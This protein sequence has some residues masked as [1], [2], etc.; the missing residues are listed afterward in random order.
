MNYH[1]LSRL[2]S[3]FTRYIF[4]LLLGLVWL[5]AAQ[6]ATNCAT[7][8]DIP[9]LECEA[10]V[11]LYTNLDGANWETSPSNNW[12]QN[13]SPCSWWGVNCT[14]SP[15]NTNVKVIRLY[16]RHFSGSLPTEL[17]NLSS[18]EELVLQ[19]LWHDNN[20][21]TYTSAISGTIPTELGN[22]TNLRILDL[23]YNNL[24]GSIPS[25]LGNLANLEELSLRDNEFYNTSIPVELGNLTNL[26]ILD[27]YYCHLT[28]SIPT[29]LGNLSSLEVL[30]LGYNGL[31][32]PIP[33]ELG[34]LSNLEYLRLSGCYDYD[35]SYCGGGTT[36]SL[37]GSIPTEL[38]NL[39]NLKKLYL[40][41]NQL[42]GDIPSSFIA[43][44][45]PNLTYIR[46]ECNQLTAS[47][48][49]V[50]TFLNGLNSVWTNQGESCPSNTVPN[51]PTN[52]ATTTISQTA[53]DLTWTDNSNIETGFIV[54]RD[55]IAI[56]T[57]TTDIANYSDTDLT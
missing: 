50:V 41:D 33:A 31:S 37:S 25:Q 3:S 4:P 47:D 20:W 46:L 28:G 24:S 7:Q 11:A 45:L 55:G 13:D 6:A 12:N 35:N 39:T 44:N 16:E 48:T 1:S 17:G 21:D 51:I 32:G 34:N 15:P 9:Q 53:I 5:S 43:T 29:Q 56:A 54:K 19:R 18:L 52:L 22:L 27:L 49:N 36:D 30:D 2:I 8:T 23:N 14:A 10:L 42:T 40:D 38:G 26:K 57:P